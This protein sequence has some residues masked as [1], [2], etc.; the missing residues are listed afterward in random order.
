MILGHNVHHP[1]LNPARR[2][3]GIVDE[4]ELKPI[5]AV[6]IVHHSTLESLHGS[7]GVVHY[8]AHKTKT[9][10]TLPAKGIALRIVDQ[11]I[12]SNVVDELRSA[13]CC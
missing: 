2:N 10:T 5:E 1:D 13:S 8:T 11:E 3:L 7:A 12:L 6:S 4:S 9:E